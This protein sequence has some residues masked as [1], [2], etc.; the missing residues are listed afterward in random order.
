MQRPSLCVVKEQVGMY[1]I[2]RRTLF[3]TRV[4][5]ARDEQNVRGP[6]ILWVRVPPIGNTPHA[7]T[8]GML[9]D[10]SGEIGIRNWMYVGR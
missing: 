1:V 5:E 8:Q 10:N 6:E 3:S 9:C 4:P 7:C 2:Q